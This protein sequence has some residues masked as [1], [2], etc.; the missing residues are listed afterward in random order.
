MWHLDIM[1]YC[2]NIGTSHFS[3]LDPQ[4][5]S[6]ERCLFAHSNPKCSTRLVDF[7]LLVLQLLKY[8]L[9]KK[10]GELVR[11]DSPLTQIVDRGWVGVRK[12]KRGG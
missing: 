8:N 4:E 6:G 12:I 1:V 2:V 9:E 3:F 11:K 5:K 7:L 10:S